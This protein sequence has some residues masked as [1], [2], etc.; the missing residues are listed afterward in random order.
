MWV[1]RRKHFVNE[2]LG[3]V[4]QNQARNAIDRHEHKADDNEPFARS[5]KSFNF[6]LDFP[7]TRLGLRQVGL[8]GTCA[9]PVRR[10]LGAH[11]HSHSSAAKSAHALFLTIP[12]VIYVLG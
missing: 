10:A 1:L 11:A 9:A 6:R 2:R 3:C 12:A 5:H 7:Q 4:R 8:P